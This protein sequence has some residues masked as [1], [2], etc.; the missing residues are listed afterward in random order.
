MSDAF[1]QAMQQLDQTIGTITNKVQQGQERV[2][3]YK[4]QM[5]DKLTE[6]NRQ[7]LSL[8]DN[9]NLRN[10]PQLRQQ[11]QQSQTELGNKTEELNRVKS[12]LEQANR[13]LAETRNSVEQ[14]NRQIQ[15]KTQQIDELNRRNDDLTRSNEEKDG[16][17]RE[18]TDQLNTLNQQKRDAE[19][20]L[21]NA[22]RQIDAFL[23]QISQINER[24][25]QQ[26]TLIDQIAGELG[27]VDDIGN[28]TEITDNINAIINMINNPDA[29]PPPPPPPMNNNRSVEPYNVEPNMTNLLELDGRQ[30]LSFIGRLNGNVQNQ[31]NQHINAARGGDQDAINAIKQ[32]LTENRIVVNRPIVG[33][34]RRKKRSIKRKYRNRNKRISRKNKKY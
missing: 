34:I 6:I 21:S 27:N 29:V 20:R 5:V 1:T 19:E 11:L 22:Q 26:I 31:I 7:L 24:L 28:F 9:A 8:R 13:T 2:R 12:D 32:I 4:Q 15:E 30:F 33:G 10:V 16:R 18:L 3:T 23:Q 25:Q 17:L 14:L